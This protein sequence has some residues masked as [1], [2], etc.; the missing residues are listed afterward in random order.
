M[1]RAFFCSMLGHRPAPSRYQLTAGGAARAWECCPRC[2]QHH[3]PHLQTALLV[4]TVDQ[5]RLIPAGYGVAWVDWR[6][7][8]A[9][10]MPIPLNLA[11]AGA[12][13]AWYWVKVPRALIMDTRQAYAK[14]IRDGQRQ[15]QQRAG[16]GK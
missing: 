10:V 9:V 7:G 8:D 12:R 2:Q 5:G 6:T 14:G 4:R 13:R 16:D 3:R 1:I 15:R 11:A